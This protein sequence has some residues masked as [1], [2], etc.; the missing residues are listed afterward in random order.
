[1]GCKTSADVNDTAKKS[2]KKPIDKAAFEKK[3]NL[4]AG[5]MDMYEVLIEKH[6]NKSPEVKA[7]NVA[8]R[9]EYFKDENK[10]KEFRDM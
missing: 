9:E 5:Y 6:E 2:K 1:M 4:P 3:F 7:K 8:Y 10:R